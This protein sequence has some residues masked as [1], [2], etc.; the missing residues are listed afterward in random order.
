[1]KNPYPGKKIEAYDNYWETKISFAELSIKNIIKNIKQPPEQ[2]P[3]YNNKVG[4]MMSE[5]NQNPFLLKHKNKIV[6]GVL[7]K[8]WYIVDGQ[9]RIEMCRRIYEQYQTDDYLIFCWH[10]CQNESQVTQ[11]FHSVNQ[12]SVKNKPYIDLD[13]FA[14]LKSNSLIT[15]LKINEHLFAKRVNGLHLKT[16][17]T[18]RNELIDIKYIQKFETGQAAYKDLEEKSKEFC[19]KVGNIDDINHGREDLYYSK[20]ITCIKAQLIWSLKSTNFIEWLKDPRTRPYH[21][22]KKTKRKI[23][24]TTKQECWDKYYNGEQ[25]GECPL[26]NCTTILF[27]SN[28]NEWNAGHIRSEKNGGPT[29]L[30]NLRPICKKC[31]QAMGSKNWEEYEQ[32]LIAT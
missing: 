26:R 19:D 5:Y 12:D 24:H 3:L 29:I 20:D 21:D 28:T 7:N 15:L 17:P 4:E 30:E 14:R 13:E 25:Q 1:M 8:I 27:K 6:I 31:N 11:L 22:K 32:Q 9:H 16:I 18:F 10:V 2:G 23:P